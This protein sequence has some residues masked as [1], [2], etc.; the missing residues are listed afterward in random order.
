MSL[1]LVYI[2]GKYRGANAWAIEQNIRAAENMALAVYRVG[3]VPVCPHTMNRFFQGAI[4][5]TLAL[6][7]TMEILRRCD[8]VLMLDGWERSE[9]ATAEREHAVD[10]GMPVLYDIDV[11]ERWIARRRGNGEPR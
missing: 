9:G 10:R 8:A 4:P 3:G 11:L 2:A 7:G 1:P 6:A 5:D